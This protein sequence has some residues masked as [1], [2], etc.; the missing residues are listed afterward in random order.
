MKYYSIIFNLLEGPSDEQ[1]QHVEVAMAAEA[2]PE[3]KE[4][5]PAGMEA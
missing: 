4:V 3:V 2:G 5:L 1:I